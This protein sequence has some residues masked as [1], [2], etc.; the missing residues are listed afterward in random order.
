MN[1]PCKKYRFSNSLRSWIIS[2]F[3]VRVYFLGTL[4]KGKERIS[5]LGG[6]GG[7]GG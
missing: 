1:Q 6:G 2:I 7:G 5:V 3:A 4:A